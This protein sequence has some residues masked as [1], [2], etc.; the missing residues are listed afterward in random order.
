[1]FKESDLRH[2]LALVTEAADQIE[3]RNLDAAQEAVST[4][5][6]QFT[7]HEVKRYFTDTDGDRASGA[8]RALSND[9]P[10]WHLAARRL[11]QIRQAVDSKL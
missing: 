6:S 2:L 11:N 4:V 3:K 8:V 1:M 7:D 10:D 9:P 5:R